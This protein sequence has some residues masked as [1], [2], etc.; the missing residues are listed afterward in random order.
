MGLLKHASELA[1]AAR[2][3]LGVGGHC[4]PAPVGRRDFDDHPHSP[5]SLVS[6][7]RAS[8]WLHKG[9]RNP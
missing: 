9:P 3:D 1:A 4:I 7:A 2:D 5:S 6:A 8:I